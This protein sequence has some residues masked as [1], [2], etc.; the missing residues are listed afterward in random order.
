MLLGP[1]NAEAAA[2]L[3]A[4]GQLAGN[5]LAACVG[6]LLPL[7]EWKGANRGS[8]KISRRYFLYEDSGGGRRWPVP[9]YLA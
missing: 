6:L 4:V 2:P 1:P 7:R 8:D 5:F 3:G 9:Q